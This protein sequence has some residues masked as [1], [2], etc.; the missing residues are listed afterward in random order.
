MTST[1]LLKTE[2]S[3]YSFDDLERDKKTAWDGVRNHTAKLNLLKM[4]PGDQAF[5]YHSGDDKQVMGIA[6]C[7]GAA[8]PDPSDETGKFV[9]VDLEVGRRLARPVTL[10]EFRAAGWDQFDLVRMSRLSCMPV[11]DD[12]RDWI[13]TAEQQ[14]AAGPVKKAAKP[15]AKSKAVEPKAKVAEA[16]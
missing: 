4:K 2:P 9:C 10:A 8:R 11:P 1:F 5:I 3:T 13:V 16:K 6:T 14:P 12:V 15:K 7:V